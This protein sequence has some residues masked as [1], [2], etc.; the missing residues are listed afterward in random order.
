MFVFRDEN[1]FWTKARIYDP[2]ENGRKVAKEIEVEYRVMPPE[3]VTEQAE[4]ALRARTQGEICDD[5]A[6]LL[7]EVVS[8]WKSIKT[9]SKDG[10]DFEFSDENLK[11][12]IAIPYVRSAMIDAYFEGV[13]GK[14]RKGN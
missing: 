3:F 6:S 14:A 1:T 11:K 10:P 9:E 13:S 7:M 8:G 4:K 12:L 5:T 2:T